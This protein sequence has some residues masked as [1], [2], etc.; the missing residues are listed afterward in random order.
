M[1]VHRGLLPSVR[2]R[3]E[4]WMR[5]STVFTRYSPRPACTTH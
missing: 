4:E 3:N 5:V 1:M 2:R